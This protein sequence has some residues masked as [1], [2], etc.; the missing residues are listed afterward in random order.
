[1]L[2]ITKLIILSNLTVREGV[3][4]TIVW[5][6]VED[7]SDRLVSLPVLAEGSRRNILR[8]A[9][10]FWGKFQWPRE[11]HSPHKVTRRKGIIMKLYISRYV[12]IVQ[13]SVRE[14]IWAR[15]LNAEIPSV[16]FGN[17]IMREIIRVSIWHMCGGWCE[18]NSI[19]DQYMWSLWHFLVTSLSNAAMV[20]S[21]LFYSAQ[22]SN[23]LPCRPLQCF[24]SIF[25]LKEQI[26]A[27][28]WQLF[29]LLWQ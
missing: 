26:E 21:N 23:P 1:M 5:R 27:I 11:D 16:L 13:V 22:T 10:M 8:K 24:G 28:K 12:C 6:G 15:D 19:R 20:I 3:K 7:A 14:A 2:K 17:M 25:Y 4:M 29:H 9:W 18:W